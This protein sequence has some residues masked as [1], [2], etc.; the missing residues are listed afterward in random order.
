MFN[1]GPMAMGPLVE[2]VDGVTESPVV[3]ARALT[4]L[5]GAAEGA[6]TGLSDMVGP[7]GVVVGASSVVVGASSVVVG[8]SSV[9]VELSGIVVGAS[10]IVV[11]VLTG[12][13]GVVAGASTEPLV[14]V[15]LWGVLTTQT[16]IVRG[17]ITET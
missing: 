11:G 10:G 8:A 1:L 17:N 7:S 4:G 3:M 13:L 16:L 15:G 9:V 2:M 6:W 5:S 12:L 14:A